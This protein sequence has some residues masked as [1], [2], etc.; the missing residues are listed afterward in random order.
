MKILVKK[1]NNGGSLRNEFLA[2]NDNA[3]NMVQ[4]SKK[5]DERLNSVFDFASN[6]PV[7]GQFAGLAK[8]ISKGLGSIFEG[9]DDAYG[10]NKI[11]Y[12]N[13]PN[14]KRDI[15]TFEIGKTNQSIANIDRAGAISAFNTPS[16]QTPA[17]GKFGMKFKRFR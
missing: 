4:R 17:F 8:G 15:E 11:D 5:G 12:R 6:I 14:L 9:K 16:F 2:S 3:F 7:I 13:N 10:F 1:F